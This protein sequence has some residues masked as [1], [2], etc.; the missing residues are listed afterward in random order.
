MNRLIAEPEKNRKFAEDQP[1]T[2]SAS[3]S[4][5]RDQ[6]RFW[7]ARCRPEEGKNYAA[8]RTREPSAAFCKEGVVSAVGTYPRPSPGCGAVFLAATSA[9]RMNRVENI[10]SPP[11]IVSAVIMESLEQTACL[12]NLRESGGIFAKNESQKG[13]IYHKCLRVWEIP[14][15]E[16]LL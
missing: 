6:K 11:R 14:G 2:E 10:E 5:T 12:S 15:K 7:P 4:L 16:I 1:K 3:V 8:R 13:N 9:V